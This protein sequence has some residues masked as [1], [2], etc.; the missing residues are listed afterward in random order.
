MNGT[1]EIRL[2]VAQSKSV[3]SKIIRGVRSIQIVFIDPVVDCK[4]ADSHPM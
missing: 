2:V 1:R 3:N 4:I